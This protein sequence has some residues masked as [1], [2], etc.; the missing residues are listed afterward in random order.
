MNTELEKTELEIA[1]LKLA[2]EKH[3]LEQLQ[4]RQR[5]VDG[6]GQGAAAVGGAVG[7]SVLLTARIVKA[8]TSVV[9]WTLAGGVAVYIF[10]AV[11]LLFSE[12]FQCRTYPYETFFE[13]VG[14]ILGANH[15]GLMLLTSIG[16]VVGTAVGI[17]TALR[18]SPRPTSGR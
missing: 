1:K 13:R 3:K 15:D 8:I 4:K 17:Y 5:V 12:R 7:A 6:L 10:T 2:Q 16:A 18:R 14:C 11:K 9:L